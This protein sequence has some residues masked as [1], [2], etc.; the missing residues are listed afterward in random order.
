MKLSLLST[1][2]AAADDLI[3][4]G[5]VVAVFAAAMVGKDWVRFVSRK[6]GK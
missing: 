4:W 1:G 6:W 5:I 3:G 2:S